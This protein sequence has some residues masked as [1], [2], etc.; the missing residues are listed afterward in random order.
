MTIPLGVKAVAN[1]CLSPP[2]PD[3]L[4]VRYLSFNS[5]INSLSFVGFIDSE[6]STLQSS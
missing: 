5:S 4:E 2:K 1:K 3:N 6:F